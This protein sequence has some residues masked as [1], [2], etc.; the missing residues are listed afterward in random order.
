MN[1]TTP[2]RNLPAARP[3]SSGAAVLARYP[4]VPYGLIPLVA[5]IL[6]MLVALIPFAFGE[7]QGATQA[8]ART[9]LDKMGA[10]WAKAT[11]SGQWV[12]L[13]GRPPSQEAAKAAEDAVRRA[14]S[15]TLFGAAEPATWVISHFTWA[16]D[17]LLPSEILRPH[18]ADPDAPNAA[19]PPQPATEAEAAACDSTMTG[20]L[21]RARIEFATGSAAIGAS[22]K[23]LLDSIASAALAC[24][25]VLS[26]E[27]H[28]DDVGRSAKNSTLSRDRADAVRN[29]LVARGVPS[30][31]LQA[32]GY[33]ATR[34]LAD[35]DTADGRARNRRIEIRSVRSPPN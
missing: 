1:E 20:L 6:L 28:T 15:S 26:I 7:V 31:R 21:S 27:G 22:S 13:E 17:T 9:A 12:V 29:E 35:N 2:P 16:E 33:G 25:G 4:F 23:A 3:D 8:A 10:S 19:P 11:A 32:Q 24:R 34:P 30:N 18:T 5:L 14:R